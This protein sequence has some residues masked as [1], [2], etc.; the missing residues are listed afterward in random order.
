MAAASHI[1]FF[2]S[3]SLLLSSTL[4]A[5]EFHVGGSKG[6]TKPMGDELE[7][8]NHWATKICFHRDSLFR[9]KYENDSVLVVG[10]SAY[11]EC[12]MTVPL[13][14]FVGRKTTFTFDHHNY[15]YFISGELG[16]CKE[17]DHV[18]IKYIII[19]SIM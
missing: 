7:N 13:L 14:K 6:W 11:K 2:L 10:K 4:P 15:F 8:Y 18:N 17:V 9:F 12:D 3:V 16:N 5:Y 1:F 19:L